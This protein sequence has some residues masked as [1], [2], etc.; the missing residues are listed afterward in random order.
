MKVNREALIDVLE[1]VTPG[2]STKVRD[3]SEQSNCFVF[4]DGNVWTYDGE[5]CC[6]RPF[7]ID[8]SGAVK[9]QP[10]LTLLSR[11]NEEFVE[12]VC[13]EGELRISGNRKKSGFRIEKEVL[14]PIEVVE[15]PGEWSELEPSFADAVKFVTPCASKDENQWVLT[16]IHITP[17]FLESCDRY[18]I[19]RYS[20]LT[21][22]KSEILVRA[23]AISGVVNLGVSK[24]SE[25]ESWLHFQN[26]S[27]LV[28]S[29]RKYDQA[30]NLNL[31]PHLSSEGTEPISL[32]GGLKE[33][34]AKAEIFSSG[35]AEGNNVTITL[36]PGK[37][38]IEGRGVDGWYKEG[39]KIKY[40]GNEIKFDIACK[41][42]SRI[43]DESSDCRVS[44]D[45]LMVVGGNFVYSTSTFKSE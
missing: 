4:N 1:S 32:P 45:K 12:V 17:N 38:L 2:L 27:G 13:E 8:F 26:P 34:I 10:I 43:A 37:L 23:D 28:V 39:Q 14:L 31:E 7:T 5:I 15:R 3:I 6:S 44:A 16:C 30:Y 36:K 18:Q 35:N 41:L 25:T 33:I 24:I 21:G 42:L 29:C 11:L 22:L 40:D 9:A 19:A 20:V